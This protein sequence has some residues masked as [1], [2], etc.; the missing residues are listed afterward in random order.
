[1]TT[2]DVD[3]AF[4]CL[5]SPSMRTSSPPPMVESESTLQLQ[6]LY[7]TAR[8]LEGESPSAVDPFLLELLMALDEWLREHSEEH[9][10]APRVIELVDAILEY[11]QACWDAARAQRLLALCRETLAALLEHPPRRERW[12]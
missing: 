12:W 9:P 5:L 6:S 11:F 1:L 4:A 10:Y 8:T 7:R 2:E 3:K